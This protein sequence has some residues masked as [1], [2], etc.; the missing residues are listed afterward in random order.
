MALVWNYAVDAWYRYE[1]FDAVRMCNF[2]GDVYL[3]TSDGLVVRLTYDKESDCG[4]T[5]ESEWASGAMDFGAGYLR[6]YSSTL[7]V[8]L[9][10]ADG[11]SVDVSVV[12]DR[13]D[14]FHD[15]IASSTKAKVKNEPFMVRT[16]IKAK[17]F[18][19][20]RLLLKVTTKMPAVTVTNVEFRVRQTGYAK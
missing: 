9:K 7:W 19:Y 8:G 14:T 1:H 15:K 5:I 4:E 3:G 16:R 17:K 10:P 12:T 20:Y 6:K 13:K 2:L 11:T 18:V